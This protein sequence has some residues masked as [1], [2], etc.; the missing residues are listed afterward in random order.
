MTPLRISR[1]CP[2]AAKLSQS[3]P[4]FLPLSATSSDNCSGCGYTRSSSSVSIMACRTSATW[5]WH[6]TSHATV[7]LPTP[8]TPHITRTSTKE[9]IR[10]RRFGV[11]PLP[12]E[13]NPDLPRDCAL[14]YT[15]NST[16][17]ENVHEGED[18][19]SQVWRA[20]D[21]KNC[22]CPTDVG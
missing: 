9:R 19:T 17:H 12:V 20:I 22:Q 16:Y 14:A 5:S 4:R 10:R 3:A 6:P 11:R 2:S 7:L 8:A 13:T 21:T 1:E 18:T 15:G